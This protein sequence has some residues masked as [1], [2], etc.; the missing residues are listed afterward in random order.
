MVHPNDWHHITS[1]KTRRQPPDKENSSTHKSS[2]V[3]RR[4][5]NCSAK[6]L[7]TVRERESVSAVVYNLSKACLKM[8]SSQALRREG[9]KSVSDKMKM[10][11]QSIFDPNLKCISGVQ[12]VVTYTDSSSR[13]FGLA[14]SLSTG[15]LFI[16]AYL[17]NKPE[18]KTLK[19]GDW[20]EA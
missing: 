1:R 3:A 4:L 14:W 11:S 15:R 18:F 2:L 6:N 16:S 19:E 13:R 17:L 7:H 12:G 20:I 10:S 9:E 8:A 5:G